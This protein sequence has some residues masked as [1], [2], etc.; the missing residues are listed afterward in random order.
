[1]ASAKTKEEKAA[2]CY[3]DKFLADT[4]LYAISVTDLDGTIRFFNKGAQRLFE[5]S[6]EDAVGINI[7]QF[8]SRHYTD[9]EFSSIVSEVLDSETYMRDLIL[10]KKGGK[11]FQGR[12]R[13]SKLQDE[14]GKI[15]GLVIF[16]RD[17]VKRKKFEEEMVKTKN[18]LEGIFD[19]IT[20]DIFIVDRKLKIAR[21]NRALLKRVGKEKFTDLLEKNC[22]NV[23]YG[24][25]K[26]CKNCPTLTAFRTKEPSAV[27]LSHERNGKTYYRE[28][29]AYPI[30]DGTGKV[31]Q[32][33][34]YSKDIT[35]RK[36]LE[37]NLAK[38]NTRL[39]FLQEVSKSMH[40]VHKLSELLNQILNS[41]L[42]LGFSR[43]AIYLVSKQKKMLE[44][45]MSIGYKDD[46]VKKV[47]IPIGEGRHSLVSQLLQTK[48]PLFVDNI[49]DPN[50]K[51]YVAEELLNTFEGDS[52]LALPLIIEGEVIGIMTVDDR[53]KKM[54]FEKDDLELLK[55]FA[56]TAAIA[57]NRA[58][59]YSKLNT[60]N[61]Q[62]QEKIKDATAE[63]SY[64][65]R[66]LEELDRMKTNFL[67]T[68][69]HELKTP[70]TSIRGYSALLRSGRVGQL[71]FQQLQCL[72]V[73]NQESQKLSELI[74]EILNITKL[75]S[76]RT[77][78]I[79]QKSDMNMLVESAIHQLK[80][81]IHQKR[82][83]VEFQQKPYAMMKVDP[84]QIERVFKN[85][86]SNAIKYNKDEGYVKIYFDENPT[87]II[88]CIEDSGKGIEKSKINRLF[89]KF[90][91][92]DEH[93]IRSAGGTGIGLAVVKSIVEKHNGKI[94]IKE[95]S[96]KGTTVAFS[97]PKHI[98]VEKAESEQANLIRNLEEL[99]SVRKIFNIMHTDSSL[100][101][102]LKMILNEIHNTIGFERIRLYLLD[103]KNKVLKGEVAIGVPNFEKIQAKISKYWIV[104]HILKSRQAEIYDPVYQDPLEDNL[105]KEFNLK[106]AVMPIIVKGK[107]IG[108]V[109]A[110]NGVSKKEI[111]QE[112]LNSLTVFANSA[113]ITIENFRLY[114]ETEKKVVERTKQ[115]T[116]LNKQK[117]DFISYASHE[118]RTPL[119][120]LLGYS[121][122]MLSERMDEK[123]K[124]QSAEVIYAEATRLRDMINNLLD[125]SKI[126]AGKVKL[127]WQET[128]VVKLA[129]DAV[130]VMKKLADEKGLE[131]S[132]EASAPI[133][134][135][136]D[137]AKIEQVLLNLLSNAIKFTPKGS[138]KVLLKEKSNVVEVEVKDSGIG[139]AKKDYPKVFSKFVQIQNELKTE[140][141]TGL[142][143]PIA[144]EIINLHGGKIWINS[145]LGEGTSFTFTIPKKK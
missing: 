55:M 109:A 88:A 128:D 41:V 75:E 33:V 20:D 51:I 111:T 102:I 129:G 44:G 79:L 120:S 132:V 18:L 113:A 131:L 108:V 42:K 135:D 82:I 28:V 134:V 95:T 59:L 43:S 17:F 71:T 13:I 112:D 121:K 136:V 31:T 4:T 64:N 1:M 58:L 21:C 26:P 84:D 118:L 56:G 34:H 39:F 63:L 32:V 126:E 98:R 99:R 119:T 22:Y 80:P 67:A 123:T 23:I 143:M 7:R 15:I 140:K 8:L 89:A 29:Y 19:S 47:Q 93:M 37:M 101:Q 60:F 77:P 53:D 122:L 94:W 104:Q 62:L 69:S 127:E 54:K 14:K 76:G 133:N 145:K 5:Y 81:L 130:T 65:N 61:Q 116:K 124:K 57:I 138:V 103:N 87:E 137:R 92:L 91:Q 106:S 117:D 74:E 114:E 144:R 70:L 125:L 52:I 90:E 12:V 100:K 10:L 68:I 11:K 66:K 2:K 35:K 96:S 46:N 25:D 49:F 141:G 6:P 105:G 38:Q 48:E 30:K 110:D 72:D 107:A 9:E 115:L 85:L 45:V 78:L 142:G 3:L 40:S 36:R 24:M 139:I 16:A 73:L 86:I 83:N 27:E 97:I 50:S